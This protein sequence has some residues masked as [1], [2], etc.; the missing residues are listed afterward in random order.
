VKVLGLDV[1]S[2]VFCTPC[3]RV[4]NSFEEFDPD[5]GDDWDEDDEDDEEEDD[6]DWD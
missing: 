4:D 5:F 2:I 3:L 1:N 6:E